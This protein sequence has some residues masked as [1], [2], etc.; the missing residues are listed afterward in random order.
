MKRT[1]VLIGILAVCL[2]V[3]APASA[4][5][6]GWNLRVFAA[7]IDPDF[8]AMTYS[9]NGDPIHITGES[10]L[11]FGASLEYQFTPLFGVEFGGFT[12]SPEIKLVVDIPGYG[13]LFLADD[14]STRIL[15][16]D[17]NFHLTPSSTYFDVYLG[18]GLTSLSFGDL[19]YEVPEVGEELDI[20]TE[21]DLTWSAKANVAIALGKNSKWSAFG[22]VRYIWA[23]LEAADA[24]DPTHSTETFD[25]NTLSA[26]VGIQYHF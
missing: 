5:D 8:N 20:V 9:G 12:G 3:S 11:G 7:G 19:H 15:T 18:G 22:G 4:A 16:L 1:A 25:F 23:T 13:P 10:D 21:N 6:K 17:L 24:E 2:A 14:M 26:S